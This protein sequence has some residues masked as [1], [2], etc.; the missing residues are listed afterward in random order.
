MGGDRKPAVALPV[1]GGV[2]AVQQEEEFQ[3]GTCA[4]T[5]ASTTFI[6]TLPVP[7]WSTSW[8]V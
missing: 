1:G 4:C 3:L 2:F 8:K 7:G 5:F 6:S